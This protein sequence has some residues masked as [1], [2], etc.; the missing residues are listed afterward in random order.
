MMKTNTLTNLRLLNRI[1]LILILINTFYSVYGQVSTRF[2]E[3]LRVI[4]AWIEAQKD[5]GSIPGISAGIVS[6]Q[7]LIWK[8]ASGYSD[9]EL[10]IRTSDS[11]IY[12]I[13][14][15]SKLFTSIAIL[16][17]RDKGKLDLDDPLSEHLSWFNLQQ[18]YPE[19]SPITIRSL[20]THSSGIP[21]DS[22][23]PYWANPEFP[24]PSKEELIEKLAGQKTLYPASTIYQYSN[25]GMSLLGFLIEE[26]SGL[27][28][29]DYVNKNILS[30]L[31]LK[32]TRPLMPESFRKGKLATGYSVESRDGKRSE[33]DFF[34]TKGLVAAA[35]YSSTVGDLAK[36]IS[37]Q[38]SIR[39][40]PHDPV[41]NGNTL[42]EMQRLHWIDPD[43]KNARGLG[44]GI[45]KTGATTMIGHY[46]SC[47]GYLSQLKMIPDKKLGFIVLINCQG[48]DS[49]SIVEAMYNILQAYETAKDVPNEKVPEPETY[50]GI[51]QDFWDGEYII[52][53]WKGKLALYSLR[54][55]YPDKPVTLMKYIE[56]DMFKEIKDDGSLGADIR[57]E[58]NDKGEIYRYWIHSYY[59]VK[60]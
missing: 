42:R 55:M 51:Y 26:I 15:I 52:V 58:R 44:F 6:D 47:P 18:T 45:Y 32:N 31:D 41:L 21:R 13:C 2:S 22:D 48:E 39:E 5:Y 28:Y 10:K 60:K 4:D 24:F 53:P 11:T 36:F 40:N 23:C 35:G 59:M 38:F 37:W 27:T 16:Q 46:G 19:G 54:Y 34:Q 33:L 50:C 43:W 57:F 14:S 17:L 30:P 20:L 3:P 56:N 1:V 8:H 29:E 25:L 7:D 9:L 49:Y 12:S